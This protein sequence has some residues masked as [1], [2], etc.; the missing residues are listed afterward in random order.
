ME[1]KDSSMGLMNR[2]RS[3]PSKKANASTTCIEEDQEEL[4]KWINVGLLEYD[5]E[6]HP[7]MTQT[8][9]THINSINIS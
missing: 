5:K 6:I 3:L 9:T 7:N 2:L 1:G 8:W 4:L